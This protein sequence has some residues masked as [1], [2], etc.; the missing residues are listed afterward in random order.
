MD[1]FKIEVGKSL[2]SYQAEMTAEVI[3]ARI[4][5][6]NKDYGFTPF[7]MFCVVQDLCSFF[8]VPLPEK[9]T[10]DEYDAFVKNNLI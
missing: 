4:K 7:Q 5:L 6:M 3:A 9:P 8:G 10:I 1:K 2:F